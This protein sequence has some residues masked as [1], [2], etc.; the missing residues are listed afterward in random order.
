MVEVET[1]IS[2]PATSK[3]LEEIKDA[4]IRTVESIT[5]ARALLGLNVKFSR[6][7]VQRK[8]VD[9]NLMLGTD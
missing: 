1:K 2:H 8:G 4:D 3:V 5:F 6:F 7:V 9:V